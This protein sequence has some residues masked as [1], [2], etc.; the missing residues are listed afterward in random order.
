[1]YL[2]AHPAQEMIYHKG[3]YMRKLNLPSYFYRAISLSEERHLDRPPGDFDPLYSIRKGHAYWK[4][5]NES[6]KLSQKIIIVNDPRVF[7]DSDDLID[8][9]FRKS[10][11]RQLIDAGF[12]LYAPVENGKFIKLNHNNI[13]PEYIKTTA[14]CDKELLIPTAMRELKKSHDELLILNASDMD[15]LIDELPAENCIVYI[16]DAIKRS[17]GNSPLYHEEIERNLSQTKDFPEHNK[18][19]FKVLKKRL[20]KGD[21][22]ES[23]FNNLNKRYSDKTE[24]EINEILHFGRDSFDPSARVL[25]NLEH[26]FDETALSKLLLL[27][28]G[29]G[30][31]EINNFI[32]QCARNLEEF[33]SGSTLDSES[34]TL[35]S[36]LPKLK[37]LELYGSTGAQLAIISENISTLQNLTLSGKFNIEKVFFTARLPALEKLNLNRSDIDNDQLNAILLGAPNIKALSLKE[38]TGFNIEDLSKILFPET[39]EELDLSGT[40][41]TSAALSAIL[42]K[43]PNLK[44][45]NCENCKKL[46][47]NDTTKIIL[48]ANLEELY[49]GE[50]TV[51]G[52]QLA[53]MLENKN[54]K[55][56]F[57]NGC[58]T[59]HQNTTPIKTSLLKLVELNIGYKSTIS[60]R[61]LS[62]IFQAAPNLKKLVLCDSRK[63]ENVALPDELEELDLDHS[64]LDDLELLEILR[65]TPKLK[66][67]VVYACDIEDCRLTND[68]RDELN[69]RLDKIPGALKE[70]KNKKASARFNAQFYGKKTSSVSHV[71]DED[72]Q[73]QHRPDEKQ[74]LDADTTV[75]PDT[76]FHV[77]RIFVAQ[78]GLSDQAP[79]YY[80]ISSFNHF[81]VNP[82]PCSLKAAFSLENNSDLLLEDPQI[83]LL[84]SSDDLYSTLNQLP[85]QSDKNYY[86]A[87]VILQLDN[88]WQALPSLSPNE[89]ITQYHL[90][91]SI[92]VDIKYSARDNLYYIRKKTTGTEAVDIDFIV[93]CPNQLSESKTNIDI[94]KIIQF[95]K[96]F[97]PASLK[98]IREGATGADYLNALIEQQVGACRHRTLVFKHLMQLNHP[99]VPVRIINNACHSFVEMKING[100]WARYDFGGYE[101]KIT[102]NERIKRQVAAVAVEKRKLELESKKVKIRTVDYFPIETKSESV[103]LKIYLQQLCN[104]VHRK[105]LLQV[106]GNTILYGLSYHL[107][108]Y[109]Q[110]THRPYF[111]VNEPDDLICASAY[112]ARHGMRGE[113]KDGPGGPL[114]R[115]LQDNQHSD[116]PPIIIVNFKNFTA[117]DMV[118]Y[119]TLLDTTPSADGT[120]LPAHAV[121]IGLIDPLMPGA[122]QDASFYSR[123]AGQVSTCPY[124][125][126]ELEVPSPYAVDATQQFDAVINLHGVKSWKE[127]LLGSWYL[128][129][130]ELCFKEGLLITALK[131]GKNKIELLNPPIADPDFDRFWQEALLKKYIVCE[132]E[133][134]GLPEAFSIA[135]RTNYDFTDALRCV[136]P[137][138]LENNKPPENAFVLN[139]ELLTHF[140]FQDHCDNTAHCI[141]RSPGIFELYANETI[142]VYLSHSITLS[143]WS[144]F[145]AEANK[146]HVQINLYVADGMKLPAEVTLLLS[147]PSVITT[148]Q[149]DH[150]RY[151]SSTDQDATLENIRAENPDALIIDVS[152]MNSAHLLTLMDGKFDKQSKTFDFQEKDGVLLRALSEGKTIILH[153]E[154]KDEL[155]HRV[156]P[157][158]LERSYAQNPSGKIIFVSN[159]KNPFSGL[160]DHAHHS[161]T[162]DEKRTLMQAHVDTAAWDDK[163]IEQKPLSQLH[164][165]ARHQC[166][167]PGDDVRNAWAGL[168]TLPIAKN[169]HVYFNL[170]D[171]ELQTQQFNSQRFQAVSDALLI[172]PYVFLAGMTGVGK[173]SFVD[174]YYQD[175]SQGRKLYRGEKELLEWA[176]DKTSGIKTL[177]IDEANITEKQWSEFEG[178]FNDPPSIVI[179]GEY[180]DLT[181]NHNVIFAGN[182]ASYSSDRQVPR[183]FQRHGGNSVIFEPIPPAYIYHEILKP[184]FENTNLETQS[185]EIST[186]I[187]KVLQFLTDC[188]RDKM[189]LTPRELTMMTQLTILYCLKHPEE[190]PIVVAQ[191]YAHL[192]ARNFV[193]TH[194]L[195]AFDQQFKTEW[196]PDRNLT[197]PSDSRLII[198]PS[199][200]ISAA[201]LDDFLQLREYR[202]TVATLS[203]VQLI[204]GLGGLT[205][206]GEPG[207]GKSELAIAMLRKHG[208]R[209]ANLENK[210]DE[211]TLFYH[212]PASMSLAK[213]EELLLHAF[214]T[215]AVVIWDEINCSASMESL[216]NSLL[217]GKT[218]D[219]KP[220]K[221][222]GFM[223][224]GTQNPTTMAGRRETSEALLHRM[225]YQMLLH[226]PDTEMINMLQKMGLSLLHTEEMIDQY[227]ERRETNKTLCFRDLMRVTDDVLTGKIRAAEKVAAVEEDQ[228]EQPAMQ[229]ATGTPQQPIPPSVQQ[230]QNLHGLFARTASSEDFL[231]LMLR[232][233][234]GMSAVSRAAL[235]QP[236]RDD[237]RITSLVSKIPG[238]SKEKIVG[239]NPD[240]RTQL[241]DHAAQVVCL[242]N[243]IKIDFEKIISLDLT[244]LSDLFNMPFDNHESLRQFI[245]NHHHR[246]TYD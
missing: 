109:C 120:L 197:L 31:T 69:E 227:N 113:M 2:A 159:Q 80:R 62:Q 36:Q 96:N 85:H 51:T 73:K 174:K 206:E 42:K 234:E 167:F 210:T 124:S 184:Q 110:S 101:A 3:S 205:I 22:S 123:F 65:K 139:K 48:P 130:K 116:Q 67:I 134:I 226:Y 180:I 147:T 57:L 233:L 32:L 117:A 230:M 39:L 122:Y 41:L 151:I 15:K 97:H 70:Y 188:S 115:F 23:L 196:L 27:H 177:F 102:V 219:G 75:N 223:L 118:R 98:N 238:I 125:Q 53:D 181:K 87:K 114:Y 217:M 220:A 34:I 215:G 71:I 103:A 141:R 30:R 235:F 187:L 18:R 59:V 214:Q 21:Y 127:I 195:E 91:K 137:T 182:P 33:Y 106:T 144:L 60:S 49:L 216:L 208:L 246:S 166:R 172:T 232:S 119:N 83:P 28:T 228:H 242:V 8:Q 46:C 157:L 133:I 45:L 100:S 209:A 66:K 6:Q 52:K 169:V 168:Q 198:T 131:D 173:T 244:S 63:I 74:T 92:E 37:S 61:Q 178:L 20:G 84:V 201:L 11:L 224:I 243:E 104:G 225:N 162:T 76:E 4:A 9:L 86:Y 55:K 240:I 194:K 105:S 164:A 213:K 140:L 175:G 72:E 54:I 10:L 160:V 237:E 107:Q 44:K 35:L 126:K 145:L 239:L 218:P 29:N 199:N 88:E 82:E 50:S 56:I 171:S 77:R 58:I 136:T 207:L 17:D 121:V 152:E 200:Q 143:E 221:Y 191:Y 212:L 135:Q 43:L 211:S 236:S 179:N 112:I 204:A 81:A 161:V 111:Y 148:P 7:A 185:A 245:E 24:A 68:E 146:H 26:H 12:L 14:G 129:G 170:E 155:I 150:T 47:E 25:T 19:I 156:T 79:N 142:S 192:L 99:D 163:F 203:P 193:P 183:F 186:P 90:S 40:D 189:L 64:R 78:E 5:I 16:E 229:S 154:F 165:I 231:S 176:K 202:Q 13:V 1:M 38:C 241:L 153:G 190:N 149:A 95:C 132:N 93:E 108:S 138:P 222:P 89:I 94:D 128:N 158:L